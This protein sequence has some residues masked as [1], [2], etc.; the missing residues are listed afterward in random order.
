MAKNLLESYSKR[1]ALAE[2][3][4]KKTHNGAGMSAQKKLMLATLLD[5]TSKF[6]NEA[7]DSSA[8]TQRSALG[9]YKRFCL[10]ITNVAVPNLILPEIML[11]QPMTS[12]AGY[13]TYLR[14]TAGTTKGGVNEG[15]FFN[16]VY[17]MGEMTEDRT[18]YTSDNVNE[19]HKATATEVAAHKFVLD[20]A[21]VLGIK[22]LKIGDTIYTVVAAG[23]EVK[24]KSVS[25][26]LATGTVTFAADDTKF[27]ADAEVKI[28]YV[29]DNVIIPQR[30]TPTSLP[31]LKAHLD[32]IDLHAHARRIAIYYSQI[33]AFQAKNDYGFDM[34]QQLATQAQ[35]EL[36][37]EID[38]EG[39]LMLSKGAEM[40]N[41]LKFAKYVDDKAISRSQYYEAFGEIVARAKKIIYTRTQKFAPNYMICGADVL[42]IL[43][44]VKGWTP[45]PASV[46]N[47]PYFAGTLD[48]LKV[49]VSPAIDEREFFFGV[50][51]NDLQTSAGVYAPYMSVVPTQLLGLPD[52][53]QTQGFSTM[54]DMRLLSTY[55]RKAD[56]G[57]EDA[58]DGE[59]SYLLVKGRLSTDAATFLNVETTDTKFAKYDDILNDDQP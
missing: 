4:H 52:G 35:G 31:T 5:N 3:V 9:D 39:V 28:L 14:Y 29:Y 20:W 55:N 15:D 22:S 2:S 53:T 7:F 58:K 8:A 33:A 25:V 21:P 46:V 12:I 26:D 40:N 41:E 6:M 37:Y 38:T 56:G 54:Y 27:I 10:N 42:T 13:I 34:A 18:R 47:G 16:G 17:R 30:E 19:T 11:T 49:F 48:S 23:S 50:N 57:I 1:I 44:Y 51:G 43:P 32:A 36:A 59:F 45:A 24:D